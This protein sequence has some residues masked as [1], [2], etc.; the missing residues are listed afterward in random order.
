MTHWRVH[1][2]YPSKGLSLLECRLETGR[3]HQIRAHLAERLFPIV[4]DWRYGASRTSPV[5]L[6]AV[7]LSF[8]DLDGK[9]VSVRK[10]PDSA[11]FSEH[12]G[13]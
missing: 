12:F 5:G 10:E 4:G 2:S 13:S 8:V 11:F 3:T 6:A 7:E 1:R 9:P